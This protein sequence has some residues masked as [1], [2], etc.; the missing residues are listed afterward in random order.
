MSSQSKGKPITN[1]ITAPLI[2]S[3]TQSFKVL[4]LNPNF[5]SIL[6][7]LQYSKGSPGRPIKVV[8]AMRN[9]AD[10]Q[11]ASPNCPLHQS[12][13]TGSTPLSTTKASTAASKTSSIEPNRLFARVYAFD[14]A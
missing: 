1:P 7:W 5:S 4:R 3:V 12:K 14:F 13:R 2:L 9:S 8:T 10:D 11:F 6:N